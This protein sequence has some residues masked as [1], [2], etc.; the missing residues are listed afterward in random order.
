MLFWCKILMLPMAV[1]GAAACADGRGAMPA[2]CEAE[3]GVMS[4]LLQEV[5]Q[6]WRNNN[7]DAFSQVFTENAHF[8]VG[9]GTH[10]EGRP[11]IFAYMQEAYGDFLAGSTVTVQNL[12]AQCLASNV[13]LLHTTGGILLAGETQVPPER[14]GLQTTVV[15]RESDRWRVIAYQNTR[16]AVGATR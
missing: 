7:A 15:V 1:F 5:A 4:T 2:T 11:A 3:F 9:D 14:I 6:T 12:D 16:I 8:I 10:L 13:G